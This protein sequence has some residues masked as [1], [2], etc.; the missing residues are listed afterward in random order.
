M[1]EMREAAIREGRLR[2]PLRE[3]QRKAEKARDR[4][5]LYSQEELDYADAVAT[6]RWRA[7]LA[8]GLAPNPT[9]LTENKDGKPEDR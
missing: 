2:Q 1:S 6:R 4:S 8:A 9:P 3:L 5:R 7:I